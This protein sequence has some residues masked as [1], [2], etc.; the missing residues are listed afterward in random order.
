MP[1]VLQLLITAVFFVVTS[2]GPV[3]AQP[4]AA[5]GGE[6]VAVGKPIT[7]PVAPPQ[8]FHTQATDAGPFTYVFG[9]LLL[10]AAVAQVVLIGSLVILLIHWLSP[11]EKEVGRD[12]KPSGTPSPAPAQVSRSRQ[13]LAFG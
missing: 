12:A 5:T 4:V 6:P 10:L 7:T 8:S 9:A 11:P 1:V 13:R 2:T 3:L